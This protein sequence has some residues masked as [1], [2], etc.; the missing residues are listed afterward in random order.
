MQGLHFL[1]PPKLVTRRS[2][3]VAAAFQLGN[4]RV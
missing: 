2:R 1:K 4:D 3:I